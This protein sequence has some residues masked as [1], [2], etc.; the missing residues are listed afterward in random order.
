MAGPNHTL[1]T[2]GTAVFSNPL[3]VEDFVKRS[4]VICYTPEGLMADAPATQCLA[5]GEGLW[6][7]ALSAGLRRRV[8][9]Q[10]EEAVSFDALDGVDLTP[11]AWP[12]DDSQT[13]TLGAQAKA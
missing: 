2:G 8:L 12:G 7:H 9:E 6:A 11:V 4:S 3:S 5:E 1:P 13:V 10:G